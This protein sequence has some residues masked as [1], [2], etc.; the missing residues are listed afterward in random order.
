M[1]QDT[2]SMTKL[3]VVRRIKEHFSRPDAKMAMSI[4]RTCVYRGNSD[5]NSSIRCA[6]GVLIPDELYDLAMEGRVADELL[7]GAAVLNYDTGESYMTPSMQHLF[8]NEVDGNFL[9]NLQEIHDDIALGNG[10][11][12]DIRDDLKVSVFLGEL[13]RI[14]YELVNSNN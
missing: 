10:V 11:F 1:Q 4:T 12:Y 9:R 13:T 3:D 7:P 2:T 5:A 6:F 8:A 14:E